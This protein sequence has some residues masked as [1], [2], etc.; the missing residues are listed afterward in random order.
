MDIAQYCPHS[1]DIA[2]F[3]PLTVDIMQYC[4]QI[5]HWI[6]CNT[7]RRLFNGVC[8]IL[9]TDYSMDTVQYCP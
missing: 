3:C 4:P 1:M 7:V 6:L 8:A 2:Q 9:S 5:I